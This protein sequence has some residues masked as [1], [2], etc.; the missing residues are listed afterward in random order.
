MILRKGLFFLFFFI[1]FII[2]SACSSED[3][4]N[5]EKVS[6][7]E[8]RYLLDDIDMK[9]PIQIME[10]RCLDGLDS[11]II[12][13]SEENSMSIETIEYTDS[14]LYHVKSRHFTNA[15][16]SMKSLLCKVDSKKDISSYFYE[17]SFQDEEGFLL[18]TC[19]LS[20]KYYGKTSVEMMTPFYNMEG[21]RFKKLIHKANNVPVREQYYEYET[22]NLMSEI[23][24]KY[25]DYGN[26]LY[27]AHKSKDKPLVY[28]F[29]NSEYD[30][31]NHWVRRKVYIDKQ[32]KYFDVKSVLQ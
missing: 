16:S 3:R 28:T 31:N 10:M 12:H 13:D 24:Y 20:C 26:L 17:T 15:T 27:E 6:F 25:D 1:C 9:Y 21:K 19:V 7:I 14:S 5:T 18:D 11:I 8:R 29:E 2:F 32:P 23:I 30:A 4:T 22:D